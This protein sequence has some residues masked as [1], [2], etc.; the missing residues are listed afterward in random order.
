MTQ[1]PRSEQA[2]SNWA[3]PLGLKVHLANDASLEGGFGQLHR[4]PKEQ[5]S[6]SFGAAHNPWVLL[7]RL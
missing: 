4:P 1:A 2:L 6:N 5:L 7:I 3:D